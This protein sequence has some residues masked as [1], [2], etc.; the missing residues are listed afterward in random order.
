MPYVAKNH[1]DHGWRGCLLAVLEVIGLFVV[2]HL[3]FRAVKHFTWIGSAEAKMGLNITPGAVMTLFALLAVWLPRRPWKAYGF[4]RQNLGR[5]LAVGVW[6][7]VVVVVTVILGLLLGTSI[8]YETG[9]PVTQWAR[10]IGGSLV[11]IAA[12][13]IVLVTWPATERSARRTPVWLGCAIILFILVAPT[14]TA[15]FRGLSPLRFSLGTIWLFLA[16]GFGE[17]IFYRGYA[18]SRIALACQR[19]WVGLV[20]AAALF[21]FLHALNT[22]DYFSG[23]FQF[24]WPYA[25]QSFWFG[26]LSGVLRDK[27]GSV[28]APAVAHGLTDVFSL[29]GAMRT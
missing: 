26:I 22:V 29:F 2:T 18:Q 20:A 23:R 21:G 14:I 10:G 5:N 8:T 27:T 28:V 15:Y 7:T 11:A 25:L 4:T 16:A 9:K 3:A 24:A 19:R 17:E 6:V 13:A 12:I 1:E